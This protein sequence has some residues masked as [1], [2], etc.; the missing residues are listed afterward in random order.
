MQSRADSVISR[1]LQMASSSSQGPRVSREVWI[2]LGVL[3]VIAGGVIWG[4]RSLVE[5]RRAEQAAQEVPPPQQVRVAALGRVEPEGRVVEVVPAEGG[6]L[7]RLLV[8]EGSTV[9][10]N[11]IL[12]Y[13]DLYDLRVAERDFAASQLAE[14]QSLLQAQTTAGTA[15]LR[16]AQSR[17]TQIDG[18]QA[19][20]IQAQQA[21]VASLQAQLDGAQ[22][23][24]L[25]FQRL[26]QDGAISRQDLD[27]QQTV[28]TQLQRQIDSAQN[29]Q[30]ELQSARSAALVNAQAQV[31]SQAAGIT[32][33]QAQV[34]VDSAAQ[35]LALAQARLERAI[36]RSPRSGQVLRLYAEPGEAV[37]PSQPVLAL[38]NTSQMFVVAEVYETDVALVRV[39]Q[40]AEINSRNGAFDRTLTGRVEQVGLQIFK[41]DILDDDP[42]ANADARVVEVRIRLDQSE[43]VR[44]LTNLQVDVLI[45]I[46][47]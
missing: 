18:P 44:G 17:I 39:G 22:L 41:N 45:D 20:A 1:Y 38:G 19:A 12:G 2:G 4:V 35:N 14:A 30:R 13:L 15:N 3:L 34:Q 33:A 23:D 7:D 11:Q 28:V 21:T 24:L 40:R 31:N 37:S 27:Q 42:A 46:R 6:R 32:L 43:V 29:R 10:V 47:S 36:I 8:T 16:E 25:R 26:Y 9:T 5:T